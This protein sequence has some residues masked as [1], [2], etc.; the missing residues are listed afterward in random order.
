LERRSKKGGDRRLVDERTAI[1]SDHKKRRFV[2]ETQ[3]WGGEVQR[4][5]RNWGV[6]PGRMKT[7][8]GEEQEKG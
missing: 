6:V 3:M 7:K 4:G 1:G 2:G 5:N 8:G